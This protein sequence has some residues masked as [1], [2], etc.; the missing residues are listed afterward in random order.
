MQYFA[1]VNIFPEIIPFSQTNLSRNEIFEFYAIC[2][3]T[4][5]GGTEPR[6][7]F[8]EVRHSRRAISRFVYA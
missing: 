7:G 6:G 4:P 8:S 3:N 5:R 1:E 2:S